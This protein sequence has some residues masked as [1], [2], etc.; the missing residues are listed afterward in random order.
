MLIEWALRCFHQ[1]FKVAPLVFL[2]DGA[3]AIASAFE[4]CS[5]SG[6]IWEGALHDEG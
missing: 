5:G 3:S 1:V 4:A 6:D 2:T